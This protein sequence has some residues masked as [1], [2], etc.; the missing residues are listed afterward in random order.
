MSRSDGAGTLFEKVELQDDEE[1]DPHDDKE[2]MTVEDVT[3]EEK[4]D[5]ATDDKKPM[6][7]KDVL[8]EKMQ[9]LEG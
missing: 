7:L 5:D 1:N 2:V 9:E 8:V 6:S 4:L 3:E